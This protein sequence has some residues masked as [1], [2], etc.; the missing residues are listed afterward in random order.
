MTLTPASLLAR[1]LETLRAP[2]DSAERL[3]GDPIPREALWTAL[4][5]VAVLSVLLVG[6]LAAL[7]GAEMVAPFGLQPGL[8]AVLLCG[9]LIVFAIA[10]HY[11]GHF[12][13]G[14]GTFDGALTVV[15][16]LQFVLFCLQ[17]V[18]AFFALVAPLLGG[19]FALVAT[20]LVLWVLANFAN[21]LHRFNSLGKA[22]VMIVLA[23]L[24]I[25]LG[26]SMILSLIGVTAP[27]EMN[28]V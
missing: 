5:L 16:W 10:L 12:M 20:V 11:V 13:G 21:V 27:G 23:F 14:A 28:N 6:T 15:I 22:A 8:Y 19:L 18:H 9:N 3:L 25:G 2:A 4:A 1:V 7:T 26:L 17:V 24:G